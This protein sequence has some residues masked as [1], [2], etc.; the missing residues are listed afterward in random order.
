[1]IEQEELLLNPFPG[2]RPFRLAENFVFFGRDGQSDQVLTKLRTARFVAVVGT[3]GSG[4]SSLVA[5][6][7]LPALFSGHMPSAGSSWRIASFRPGSSPIKNLAAALC[8]PEVCGGKDA[9]DAG[10]RLDNIE[11]TLRRSSLGLL[12]VFNQS[13]MAAGENLLILADQFEELFRFRKQ[14][15]DEHPDDEAAAFVKLL[16]EAKQTNK[17]DDEKLPIYVILTMRSDYLGDCAHFWGLPEAINEGQFL[18]PRMTDDNRREAIT[19]PI[20]IGG[21][22]ITA[23]LVNRLL[24]DAGDDPAQL[25]ILQHALMRTWDHWR[26]RCNASGAIDISH[27]EAIGGMT[28]AL[29]NHADEAFVILSRGLR[30]IAAKVF[31]SL[32]EKEADNRE[33]RRPATIGEIA[34]AAEANEF[35]V[36]EVVESFRAEGCSFLMPSP[37][38]PLNSDTP[39]DISHE[40]LI[41]GWARLREW[42]DEEAEA[43]RQYVRLADKAAHFPDE[44]GY[45]SDPALSNGLKWLDDNKP[46]RAWALRYHPGFDKTIEY[47]QQ[48]KDFRQAELEEEARKHRE[49]VERDLRHAEAIAV[50]E[51][52]RVKLRNWG[53]VVL[54]ALMIGMFAVTVYAVRQKN[55]AEQQ[56]SRA[57]ALLTD[58][59]VERD[60][61]TRA[62]KDAEIQK[63]VAEIQ[64]TVAERAFATAEEQR[65]KAEEQRGKA[66]EQTKIA[67]AAR[68][69]ADRQ[70]KKAVA[71]LESAQRGEIA[72][73]EAQQRE[74]EATK[75]ALAKGEEA[76][77]LY[78]TVKEI[79]RSAPYFGAVM[80]GH[81]N[82]IYQ[83]VFSSDGKLVFTSALDGTGRVWDASTGLPTD[84]VLPKG[85]AGMMASDDRKLAL[86]AYESKKYEIWNL[87]TKTLIAPLENGESVSIPIKF[88]PNGRLLATAKTDS[89]DVTISDVASGKELA[90]LKGHTG[91][92]T[93]IGFSLDQ[94]VLVTASDDSSVRM[95]EVDSGKLI[96]TL[97]GHL[98]QVVKVAFS[99]DG[100]FLVTASEDGTARVW[101]AHGEF[102]TQLVAGEGGK[103]VRGA[104]FSPDS[105]Y[106]LTFSE[107]SASLWEAKTP[108][109]WKEL[110][111]NSPTLLKAHTANLNA[112]VFS[113]N[114]QRIVTISEDRTARIWETKLAPPTTPVTSLA[115]LAGHIKPVVSVA[116][117]ADSKSVVT[118][119]EDKTARVWDLSSIGEFSVAKS[120]LEAKPAEYT[121]KC[122]VTV[123][124]TGT[125]AAAGGSGTVKYDF[126]WS[127]GIARSLPQDLIFDGPG[128]QEVSTTRELFFK[129]VSRAN[130]PLEQEGWVELQILQPFRLTSNQATFRVVCNDPE[131]QQLVAQTDVTV[132][133]LGQIMPSLPVERREFYLPYIQKAMAEFGIDTPQRRAAFLAEVAYNTTELRFLTELGTDEQLEQQYGMN[134]MY[135]NFETG[136]GARFKGRGA[137]LMTGRSNYQTYG[138]LL[139]VDLIAQPEL[140]AS[141]EV[142]FRTAALYWQRNGLNELADK[143]NLAGIMYKFTGPGKGIRAEKQQNYFDRAKQAF[144]IQ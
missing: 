57:E 118:G 21:G 53:L 11:R 47:L 80:R 73:L 75:Q 40:S 83:S 107:K 71:A 137:F 42:V 50:G 76:R 77:A 100:K 119:S 18:I 106:I 97:S 85:L 89:N 95:W 1:M 143:S 63:G 45:L 131:Q 136:D 6:G 32:T 128:S 24:N 102:L 84:T 60:H 144:G 19:G 70:T 92:I 82:I 15:T 112:A 5:A 105:R 13:R 134:K 33:G 91:Q 93:D 117:S 104:V 127:D 96:A 20:I 133:Q 67:Q 58:V 115:T 94:V 138:Q 36:V 43:A 79:D 78:E 140:A 30:V 12:E 37:P 121:G 116:F 17:S 69:E 55:N 9:N 27:Y 120:T 122:P 22:E 56:K 4:K 28:E 68:D 65:G 86:L 111:D 129:G 108:G 14:S 109:N 10:E 31:K 124:F 125:V 110:S 114:G 99:P 139:G 130:R 66:E 44:E 34:A 23:P 74:A 35:A 8:A 7:L 39:V 48:S 52:K 64:K 49:E 54:S 113:P 3:S 142:A 51:K 135:G 103:P 98:K 90:R 88:S 29:S 26:N 59:Q 46:T 101:D 123:K 81:T 38:A 16:L 87:E 2:L 25:P 62:Q 132:E 126:V 72:R 61:A 41:R 141:P